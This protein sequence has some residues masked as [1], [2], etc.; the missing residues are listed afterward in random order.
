MRKSPPFRRTIPIC[1]MPDSLWPRMRRRQ[2]G[3]R[4]L[5]RA[6][7]SWPPVNPRG[8]SRRG[9]DQGCRARCRARRERT[10]PQ[11]FQHRSRHPRKAAIGDRPHSWGQSGSTSNWAT[12]RE[13]PSWRRRP[14]GLPRGWAR[15]DL[16]ARGK[17]RATTRQSE[18]CARA[19][20]DRLLQQFRTLHLQQRR[21]FIAC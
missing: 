9:G 7:R 21:A 6:I 17:F 20:Y 14:S 5:W 10:C 4:R 1:S 2:A 11:A 13:S 16:A 19:V 18:S 12:T 8:N 3:R 15:G